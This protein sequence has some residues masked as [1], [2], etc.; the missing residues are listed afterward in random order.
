M[1]LS[2]DSRFCT[3]LVM[4]DVCCCNVKAG[5]LSLVI[6]FVHIPASACQSV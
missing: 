2:I 3:S 1:T 4:Q 6:P 5:C